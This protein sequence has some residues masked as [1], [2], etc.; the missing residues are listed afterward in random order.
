V[1]R[2]VKDEHVLALVKA[3]LKAGILTRLGENRDTLTGMPQR[4]VAQLGR[5][6]TRAGSRI[7]G[8]PPNTPPMLGQRRLVDGCAALDPGTTPGCVGESH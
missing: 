6:L 2:R 3:F 1:R 8:T 7:S 4:D 5:K